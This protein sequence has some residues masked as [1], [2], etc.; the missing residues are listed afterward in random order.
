M[1][2]IG[3]WFRH[4]HQ[5]RQFF[6]RGLEGLCAALHHSV[7][8]RVLAFPRPGDRCDFD[9]LAETIQGHMIIGRETGSVWAGEDVG[10]VFNV[11]THDFLHLRVQGG[12][13]RRGGVNV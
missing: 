3:I 7:V 5:S 9:G 13:W 8:I 11:L 4:M 6:P 10:N 1:H 2:G 12:M